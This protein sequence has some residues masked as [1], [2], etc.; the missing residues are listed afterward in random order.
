TQRFCRLAEDKLAVLFRSWEPGPL[1]DAV[2]GPRERHAIRR[3]ERAEPARHLLGHFRAHG[4][5]RRQ[6]HRDPAQATQK[7]SAVDL[8]RSS[9]G[10]PH[11]SKNGLLWTT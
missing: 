4:V 8:Q 7:R 2:F 11:F 3:V 5:E 10:L 1:V 9:H 6:G